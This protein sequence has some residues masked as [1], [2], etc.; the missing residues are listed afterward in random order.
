MT[1]AEESLFLNDIPGIERSGLFLY[2][3]MNKL[4]ITLN[5]AM[6]TGKKILLDLLAQADIFI[7]NNPPKTMRKLGLSYNYV[8][9]INPRMIMT[10][11]TPFGQTGPY[12]DY[13]RGRVDCHAHGRR[14]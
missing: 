5:P 4:G 14:R 1:A 8:K 3:N 10:C 11:I 12:K 2:L 13:E 9:Q 6:P 7:E